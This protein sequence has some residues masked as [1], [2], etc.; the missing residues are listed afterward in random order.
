MHFIL[1]YLSVVELHSYKFIVFYTH[2]VQH[3]I[4]NYIMDE[5]LN[6]R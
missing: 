5:H 6:L 2:N 1:K 3:I 4:Y